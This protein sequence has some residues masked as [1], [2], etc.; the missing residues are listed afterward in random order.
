MSNSFAKYY[1]AKAQRLNTL[2]QKYQKSIHAITWQKIGDYHVAEEITQDVF[3]Q[4]YNKLSTLKDPDKFARWLYVIAKRR[5]AN[6]LE[7]E[8]PTIQS[9]EATDTAILE[10]SAYQTFR[11]KPNALALGCRTDQGLLLSK[12]P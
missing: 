11:S 9:L 5:C 10:K 2:F 1:Q 7:R 8:K 4:A 6:W 3:L 12:K